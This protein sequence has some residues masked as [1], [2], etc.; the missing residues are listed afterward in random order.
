MSG[1]RAYIQANQDW[2]SAKARE[3]DV[4]E[5]TSG[6]YYRVLASGEDC[7]RHPQPSSIITAHYTGRTID[8]RT[9][10][11]SVGSSPLVIRLRQLI[12]GWI[13]AMQQ[14]S[15]GDKWE[16]YLSTEMGY[17]KLSQSGIPAG[18][19]LIFEV[20]LLQFT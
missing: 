6:V 3:A 8:G 7:S 14:M 10:D 20:E 18:S 1:K 5:I 9:F 17:G 13:V 11:T 15:V 4:H 19:T 16:I 12:P 2:L